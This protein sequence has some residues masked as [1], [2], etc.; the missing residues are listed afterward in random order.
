MAPG[1]LCKHAQP[2]GR[3]DIGNVVPGASRAAGTMC[4]PRY[5]GWDNSLSWFK[6]RRQ[7]S[8]TQPI[9]RS[10]HPMG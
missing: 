2:R 7:L 8:T 6:P 9:A 3:G 1:T 5:K 4:A 10:S